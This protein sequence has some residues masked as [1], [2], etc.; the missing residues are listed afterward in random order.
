MITPQP[1][2]GR[3]AHRCAADDVN[4]RPVAKAHFQQPTPQIDIA[5]HGN[6]A[7]LAPDAE[8]V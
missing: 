6:N 5:A 8:A 2:F 3:I 7:S 4:G 1:E